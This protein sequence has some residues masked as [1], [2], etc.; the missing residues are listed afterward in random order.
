MLNQ[1]ERLTD[2][3]LMK[4][5]GNQYKNHFTTYVNYSTFPIALIY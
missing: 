4:F 2:N 5:P 1:R 3:E